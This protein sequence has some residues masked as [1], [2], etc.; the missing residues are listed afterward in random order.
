MSKDIAPGDDEFE[1]VARRLHTFLGS[2]DSAE[3]KRIE[4]SENSFRAFCAMALTEIASRL[5]YKVHSI[6]EFLIDMA[7]SFKT[8][9]NE[10]AQRAHD[11]RLRP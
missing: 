5:G 7:W 11:R 2:L 6:E 4:I 3:I 10:G 9:W 1:D 8:G